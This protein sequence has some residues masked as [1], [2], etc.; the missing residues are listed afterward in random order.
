MLKSG[1][2]LA[3]GCIND[4]P[5]FRVGGK[6]LVNLSMRIR[7]TVERVC[8]YCGGVFSARVDHIKQGNGRFCSLVCAGSAG[9]SVSQQY[10]LGSDN[11]NQRRHAHNAV[12]RAVRFGHITAEP[13][14][15][16]GQS[17]SSEA[18]HSDYAAP[19][20]IQWLCHTHHREAHQPLSRTLDQ[21]EGKEDCLGRGAGK[22]AGV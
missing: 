12:A 9:G 1:C 10:T 13:C 8:S 6:R 7:P 15:V 11:P 21:H 5:T 3:C 16:C 17:E 22:Y 20:A 2:R 19:L 4:L 18:H 14:L